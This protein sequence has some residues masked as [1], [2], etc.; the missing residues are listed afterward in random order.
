M[1]CNSCKSSPCCCNKKRFRGSVNVKHVPGPQGEQGIQG[2]QGPQGDPGED[3]TNGGMTF[4]QYINLD[5]DYSWD[6]IESVIPAA[7]HNVSADGNYQVHV[8]TS[9]FITD[10]GRGEV[11]LYANGIMVAN[12]PVASLSESI[13]PTVQKNHSMNWRGS[14]LL[15]ETIEIRV[16]KSNPTVIATNKVNLLINKEA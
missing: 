7:T 10:G 1:S 15:G 4:E 16:V 6:E 14:L 11:R 5:I 9:E 13:S 8:S 3:G 2:E 12:M